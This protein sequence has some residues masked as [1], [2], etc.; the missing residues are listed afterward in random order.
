VSEKRRRFSGSRTGVMRAIHERSDRH[1]E[2]PPPPTLP[3]MDDV[4]GI[5]GAIDI[6]AEGEDRAKQADDDPRRSAAH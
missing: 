6:H 5:T 3:E 4:L 1:K 2:P